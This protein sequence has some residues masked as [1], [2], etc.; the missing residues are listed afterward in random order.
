ME[1][2]CHCGHDHCHSNEQHPEVKTYP[3]TMENLEKGIKNINIIIDMI[4]TR[5][6][7][8]REQMIIFLKLFCDD[9]ISRYNNKDKKPEEKKEEE[10][11]E[12][13]I[14]LIERINKTLI[15]LLQL[16]PEVMTKYGN[17]FFS[18]IWELTDEIN[19]DDYIPPEEI[20][21]QP[22]DKRLT[23]LELMKYFLQLFFGG[24]YNIEKLLEEKY[25][26]IDEEKRKIIINEEKCKE[27]GTNQDKYI[28]ENNLLSNL[29]ILKIMTYIKTDVF[30]T[31]VSSQIMNVKNRV[32]KFYKMLSLFSFS[33]WNT[34]NKKEELIKSLLF[35]IGIISKDLCR[36]LLKTEGID[37][38]NLAYFKERKNE[39]HF[40]QDIILPEKS[41]FM[42]KKFLLLN[43]V[44][45]IGVF[46]SGY[47]ANKPFDI[48]DGNYWDEYYGLILRL[49][50]PKLTDMENKEIPRMIPLSLDMK[51]I[52]IL[53][54]TDIFFFF[55]PHFCY[56]DEKNNGIST[57]FNNFENLKYIAQYMI[58]NSNYNILTFFEKNYSHQ[59]FNQ[60]IKDK[61]D[62]DM[63]DN[64][65]TY[66]LF[67]IF[68]TL[69]Q[70]KKVPLI[71]NKNVYVNVMSEY[72]KSVIKEAK[73]YGIPDKNEI[74][75]KYF[76]DELKRIKMINLEDDEL[77]AYIN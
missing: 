20:L 70:D 10:N 14:P 23:P 38:K 28:N 1:H 63:K 52:V 22:V 68:F 2:S 60:Y 75:M 51:S 53:L 44:N 58:I 4:D 17:E 48:Q 76:I 26:I 25:I 29:F 16:K 39:E 6:D 32:I 34:L 59:R 72:L 18:K 21:E 61:V 30:Y 57:M 7:E 73:K 11:K 15:Q 49:K 74:L 67:F 45:I 43:I 31:E 37:F 9:L 46:L 8:N 47:D 5:Q 50:D 65:N 56:F 41:V 77:K 33:L 40:F 62:Y 36:S 19:M 64:F 3:L 13:E 24:K 66:G 55:C 71:I 12:P 27:I 35:L 42:L 54:L 69:L